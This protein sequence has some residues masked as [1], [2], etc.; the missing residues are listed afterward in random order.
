MGPRD[1]GMA[2]A[3]MSGAGGR[4]ISGGGVVGAG[5]GFCDKKKACVEIVGGM[6]SIDMVLTGRAGT[7]VA[8]FACPLVFLNAS[9]MD[10]P[11]SLLS[12][13]SSHESAARFL[14]RR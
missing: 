8:V 2:V 13:S 14:V 9:L 11:S 4:G 7:S 1:R 5:R 12:F 6:D 3:G 10:S